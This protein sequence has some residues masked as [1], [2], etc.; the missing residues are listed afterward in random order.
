MP[1]SEARLVL[2]VVEPRLIHCYWQVP[3]SLESEAVLRFHRESGA[4]F[5]IEIDLQA[6]SWYVPLWSADESLYAELIA[7]T[8][9]GQLKS[10]ARSN[11][12]YLPR[13]R[14]V[15]TIEQ[16]FIKIEPETRHIEVV[17][18][19]APAHHPPL[20]ERFVTMKEMIETAVAPTET[21]NTREED[22]APHIPIAPPPRR[23]TRDLVS[24]VEATLFPGLSSWR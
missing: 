2:L 23:T 3:S 18:P 5:D 7:Q 17:P 13:I 9:G 21:I 16:H 1:V 15:T 19:P 14:P 22:A 11:L 8:P 20:E 24:V 12:V 4:S 6:G 10:L